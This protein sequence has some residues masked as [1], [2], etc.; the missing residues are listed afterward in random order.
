MITIDQIR[1]KRANKTGSKACHDVKRK[2]FRYNCDDIYVGRLMAMSKEQYMSLNWI[3]VLIFIFII[4]KL[5]KRFWLPLIKGSAGE[6]AIAAVL[7]LLNKKEY[8]VLNNVMMLTE[9]GTSQI[10]HIVVSIYGIFVIEVKNYKGWILGSE[11]GSKWT[12]S[13]YGHKNQFM[14]PIHQNYGHVKAIEALLKNNGLTDVPIIPIV[15]FPGDATIKVNINKALVVKWGE[16]NGTIR[17]QSRYAVLSK[18]KMA[19]IVQLLVS[20]KID[21]KEVR[22]EHIDNIHK[23]K[24]KE[25]IAINEGICPKCGGTLILKSGKY[26]DFYGCGNYPECRYTKKIY[27]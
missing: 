16:L 17:D 27:I 12:Q 26:G 20:S 24:M 13:I 9:R 10:D 3:W 4:L 19:D 11:N 18:E 5:T 14:N 21:S 8:A 6:A 23:K 25:K 2:F 7:G 22:K 1:R 15:T